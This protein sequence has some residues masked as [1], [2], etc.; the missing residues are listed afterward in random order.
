MLHFAAGAGRQCQQLMSTDVRESCAHPGMLQLATLSPQACSDARQETRSR[1]K[2]RGS[3]WSL[4]TWTHLPPPTP[5]QRPAIHCTTKLGLLLHTFLSSFSFPP[6]FLL[7]HPT[8][9]PALVG[10][11]EDLA[12]LQAV[13][14]PSPS[15]QDFD[16][17]RGRWLGEASA[18]WLQRRAR[19]RHRPRSRHLRHRGPAHRPHRC[20]SR[21]PLH[22]SQLSLRSQSCRPCP[23]R[24]PLPRPRRRG[25]S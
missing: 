14:W 25:A 7:S 16:A 3:T 12:K 5:S 2:A 6:P 17:P 20:R 9:A 19:R 11:F 22:Q 21:R 1:R 15:Y 24:P 8:N 10:M 4:R 18:A 23:R 13:S